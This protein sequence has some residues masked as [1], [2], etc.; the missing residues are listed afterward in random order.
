MTRMTPQ[1]RE[2]SLL[3]HAV[4]AAA[5]DG[6]RNLTRAAIA[7]RA[8]VSEALV[9]ARLG[10][11][12]QVRRSVMRAAVRDRCLPVIAEGLAA[13]DAQALRASDT[14]KKLAAA[15]LCK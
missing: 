12:Q 13:R 3:G 7:Q 11:M 8:G 2:Q 15:L 1:D 4:A 10:T 6:W 9:S 14:L 5:A